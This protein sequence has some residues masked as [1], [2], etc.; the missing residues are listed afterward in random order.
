MSRITPISR[1][2]FALIEDLDDLREFYTI[3]KSEFRGEIK[4]LHVPNGKIKT[5]TGAK[6]A[7]PVNIDNLDRLTYVIIKYTED[8]DLKRIK[9]ELPNKNA[10]FINKFFYEKNK[11]GGSRKKNK[12]KKLINKSMKKITNLNKTTRYY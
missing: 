11:N 5:I 3:I 12:T 4:C 10:K 2:K 1:S 8:G 9:I 7:G 6:F